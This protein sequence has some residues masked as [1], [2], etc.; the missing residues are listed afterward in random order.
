MISKFTLA[1]CT[2]AASAVF[3]SAVTAAPGAGLAPLKGIQSSIVEEV[4]GWHRT[5]QRGLNGYH[6]HVKGVGRI[7][8]TNRRCYKNRWGVT[9]CRWF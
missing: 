8:C 6:R 3:A 2:L 1:A 7:Q 4:H 9:R 5:C